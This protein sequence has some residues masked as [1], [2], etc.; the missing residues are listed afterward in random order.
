MTRT[1]RILL[2]STTALAMLA[3]AATAAPS[4]TPQGSTAMAGI[5]AIGASPMHAGGMTAG[6]TAMTAD[7][8]VHETMLT[9]LAMQAHTDEHGVDA[10]AAQ[11]DC[12]MLTDASMNAMHRDGRHRPSSHHRRAGGRRP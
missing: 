12:P 7:N 3:T 6:H 1:V 4:T 2:L 9:D 8:T 5:H 10:D 11:A